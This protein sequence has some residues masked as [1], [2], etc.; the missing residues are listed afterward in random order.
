[1]GEKQGAAC[2]NQMSTSEIFAI[3]VVKVV[4]FEQKTRRVR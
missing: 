3:D 1:M 4:L 2:P